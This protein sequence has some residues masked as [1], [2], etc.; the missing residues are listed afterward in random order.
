M[1]SPWGQQTVAAF[2]QQLVRLRKQL[3]SR[4]SSHTCRRCM[5]DYSNWQC[6][7]P[8]CIPT[9]SPE[10]ASSIRLGPIASLVVTEEPAIPCCLR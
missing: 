1:L 4:R 10:T 3:N 5:Y 6:L 9:V 2:K 7:A 8:I